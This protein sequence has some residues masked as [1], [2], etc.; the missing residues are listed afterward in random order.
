MCNEIRAKKC[1]NE[2]PIGT[3]YPSTLGGYWEKVGDGFFK[4]Y[5]GDTF[6]NVGGGWN[7]NVI[8]PK[9]TFSQPC[10]I[11]KNSKEL[12]NKLE[13]LGYIKDESNCYLDEDILYVMST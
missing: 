6:T 9:I 3:K 8:L 2:Y 5:K 1:V 13:E 4:W 11:T 7:R 12:W 10:Y